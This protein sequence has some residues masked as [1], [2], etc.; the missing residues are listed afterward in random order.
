MDSVIM[1]RI[2]PPILDNLGITIRLPTP[3]PRYVQLRDDLDAM[4]R[5]RHWLSFRMRREYQALLTL[6]QTRVLDA[7]LRAGEGLIDAR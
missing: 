6:E 2:P 3:S 5:L 1:H 4:C 7:V